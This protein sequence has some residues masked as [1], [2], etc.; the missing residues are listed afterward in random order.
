MSAA[1]PRVTHVLADI[2]LG[3]D[4]SMVPADTLARAQARGTAV[5][6]LIEAAAYGYLDDAAVDPD[7]APYLDAYR[8]FIAESGAD[9]IRSEFEVAHPVYRY[10]G[11]PDGLYWI[12]RR[13]T[14]VDFK[15]GASDGA[16]YQLA[17]YKLAWDAA[18]PTEPIA[19]AAVVQLR[20]DGAYALHEVE[21]P[22]AENVWLSAI[23]VYHA[24]RAN[25]PA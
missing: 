21:L 7:L 9:H 8:K 11:H 13:R 17:A 4:L 6:A 22:A 25:V 20:R 10:I 19:A 2:G 1:W 18:N 15:T 12:V 14:L 24:K 3:P 16:S 23:T 5:H